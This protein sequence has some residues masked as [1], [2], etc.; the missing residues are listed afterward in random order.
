MLDTDDGGFL[1]ISPNI[2]S[3]TESQIWVNAGW[4]LADRWAHQHML[5]PSSTAIHPPVTLSHAL[6]R[7]LI[8]SR[9]DYSNRLLGGLSEALRSTRWTVLWGHLL[10]SYFRNRG[11]AI[12]PSK[13]TRVCTDFISG[14][15]SI[16]GCVSVLPH[17]A[18]LEWTGSLISCDGLHSGFI[19]CWSGTPALSGIRNVGST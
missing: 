17:S 9:H 18:V 19:C 7:A 11:T 10:V 16:T 13:W 6:I 3:S 5:R 8:L 15:W 4:V 1:K 12:S 2:R 14:P